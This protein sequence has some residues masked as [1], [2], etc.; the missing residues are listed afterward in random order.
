MSVYSICISKQIRYNLESQK[1]TICIVQ[2]DVGEL[3]MPSGPL[4]NFWIGENCSGMILWLLRA[5]PGA[6]ASEASPLTSPESYRTQVTSNSCAILWALACILWQ[7]PRKAFSAIDSID[8]ITATSWR[9]ITTHH[10]KDAN[11]SRWWMLTVLWNKRPTDTSQD[12]RRACTDSSDERLQ[13]ESL[14]NTH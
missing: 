11:T 7:D 1:Y 3:M 4:W 13:L 5:L 14:G 8:Y 6:P 9:E 10:R 12:P 2:D